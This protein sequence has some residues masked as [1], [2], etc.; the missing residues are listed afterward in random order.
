VALLVVVVV[1]IAF[2]ANRGSA[3]TE[4]VAMA[5]ATT[6]EELATTTPDFTEPPTTEPITEPPSTTPSIG[7]RENPVPAGITAPAGNWDMTIT[8]YEPG[9]NAQAYNQ[10]NDPA[11]AGSEYVR[12][13]VKA[14]YTGE[15]T[16][17]GFDLSLNLVDPTAK[18][19]DP[20]SIAGGSG[21]DP[22]DFSSQPDTFKGGTIEGYFYYAIP[23]AQANAKLLVFPPNTSYSDVPGGVGF[24]AVN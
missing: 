2:L 22:Q 3:N 16:G 23:S 19:Y 1:V 4:D 15:G 9:I 7:T 11:P 5:S 12:V 24:F 6:I 8:G 20:A 21:G 17:S 18:T 13:K 14:T 10:F